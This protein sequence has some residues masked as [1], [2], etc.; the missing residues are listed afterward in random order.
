MK[1]FFRTFYGKLSAVF[2]VLLIIMGLV[3]TYI[4][5]QTSSRFI[6]EVDQRL[7]LSLARDMAAEIKPFLGEEI[8]YASIK[9]AIHYMMV[10]NPKVEIYLLDARGQ[11]LSFFAEPGK[12]V[13]AEEVNLKPIHQ[14]L[15]E[16]RRTPILG[17]DPRHPRR[18]KPF[19]VAQLSLGENQ[20][21]Y[22]YIIIGSEQYDSAAQMVRE[23]YIAK[24]TIRGLVITLFFAGII[25]LILF[26]V[27]TR[28]LHRMAQV[29]RD[30]E[31][32][33]YDK[34]IDQTSDDEIGQLGRSFNQM[35][36]TIVANMEELKR[37][38]HLRRELIANVSHDLRSPLASIQGYLETILMKESSLEPDKR[39]QFLEI[40]LKDTEQ[41]NKLVHELFE[42]SKLDARETEPNLEPFPIAELVQDVV[43]KYTGKAKKAQVELDASI[44]S[45]VPLVSADIAMMERALSN[46]IENAIDYTPQDGKIR[47]GVERENGGVEITIED[48][49]IGIPEED[50]P[51]I[52]DRFYR[53]V[54]SRPMKN[55]STGL[56]LAI[57][58]KL[59]ELHGST[60][61]VQSEVGVGTRFTF[62]IQSPSEGN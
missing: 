13:E 50:L 61:T 27:L 24:T 10:M 32:G 52:F 40:I 22:L 16:D 11:I 29:V 15:A 20:P 1:K 49:G 36:D 12:T 17:E 43:M 9:S 6:A 45:D 3:Q 38:D 33:D 55:G 2:L 8:D 54:K 56:G 46:L 25:G 57:T 60:I 31:Q 42:L 62:S 51:H 41:L 48:T 18:S 21:G 7:N 39:R 59:L 47:V 5:L 26:A 34:R 53:G 35:A 30:F 37:T 58:K 23:S 4:T 14:F 28:R 19:S 44:P